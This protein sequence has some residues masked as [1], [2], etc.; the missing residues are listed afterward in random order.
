MP[1]ALT[2]LV[3][4]VAIIVGAQQG[5]RGS[6]HIVLLSVVLGENALALLVGRRHPHAALLGVLATYAL[7]DDEATTLLPVL[8]ALFTVARAKDRWS[9]GFAAALAALVVVVTPVI[10]GNAAGLFQTLLPLLA[11]VFAVAIGI[12]HRADHSAPLTPV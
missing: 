6:T 10:H 5:P 1:F 2:L 7:V 3:G 4:A 12:N 11:I 9:G 8:L